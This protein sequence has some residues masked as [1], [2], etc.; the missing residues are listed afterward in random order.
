MI[1]NN[2]RTPQLAGFARQLGCKKSTIAVEKLDE[3]NQKSII[4]KNETR[5]NSQLKM[6]RRISELDL[7]DVLDQKEL[8]LS[9]HNRVIL[10][11]YFNL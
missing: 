9:A 5:W 3:K 8:Q 1:Q 7:E 11:F 6:V 2:L 4:S 10:K